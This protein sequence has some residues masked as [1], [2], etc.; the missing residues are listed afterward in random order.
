MKKILVIAIAVLFLLVGFKYVNAQIYPNIGGHFTSLT[1]RVI[2]QELTIPKDQTK[3]R[4]GYKYVTVIP[5]I[6]GNSIYDPI[7]YVG[8]DQVTGDP[9]EIDFYWK[10]PNGNKILAIYCPYP[11]IIS[12]RPQTSK[13]ATT[14]TEQFQ[15][16]AVCN[17]CPDGINFN[18]LPT[19]GCNSGQPSPT[20]EPTGIAYLNFK[21]TT[22]QDL[23]PKQITSVSINGTV[24]GGGFDYLGQSDWA[25]PDCTIYPPDFPA[26]ESIF[27][28]NFN[29]TLTPCPASDPQC[30]NL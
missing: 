7:L 25:S 16:I 13:T 17:F 4:D 9:S 28:G 3:F 1:L 5:P 30:Q 2:Y 20:G 8:I 12:S 22:H 10:H 19:S 11:T 26:C 15:G 24:A 23:N 6:K 29:A 14:R 18:N 21:G 27:T